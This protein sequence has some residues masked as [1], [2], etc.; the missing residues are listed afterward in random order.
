M[1]V[2][3]ES[4]HENDR[5]F[6]PGVI[7]DVDP[8]LVPLNKSFLVDHHSL[9]TGRRAADKPDEFASFHRITSPQARRSSIEGGAVGAS[10][11]KDSTS[12][13]AQ[14]RKLALGAAER[15]F[16]SRRRRSKYPPDDFVAM[17]LETPAMGEHNALRSPR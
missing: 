11:R 1:Y 15:V 7:S 3:R 16:L 4:V 13:W 14:R 2:G 10:D 6:R 17:R 9:R 12:V 8:V 5:R